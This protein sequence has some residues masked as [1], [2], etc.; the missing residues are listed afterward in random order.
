MKTEYEN[1]KSLTDDE[2]YNQIG[3]IDVSEY[4]KSD[5]EDLRKIEEILYLRKGVLSNEELYLEH[6]ECGCGRIL[7]FYDF[8]YTAIVDAGH[9]KSFIVHT[10]LGS[11]K[12]VNS[13]R[14]IRCSS[15]KD[16]DVQGE[17]T[18]YAN[19]NYGCCLK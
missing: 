17:W 3:S 2:F 11:K 19:K 6:A 15:C 10:I 12:I 1:I 4:T 5:A 14:T 7:T 8:V 16:V 18:R 9:S 13:P